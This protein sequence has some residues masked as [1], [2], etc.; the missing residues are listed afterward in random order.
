MHLLLLAPSLVFS[1]SSSNSNINEKID[2]DDGALHDANF[3]SQNNEI[4]RK[5]DKEVHHCHREIANDSN[6]NKIMTGK[7]NKNDEQSFP[8]N[9]VQCDSNDRRIV[10]T[11][12]TNFTQ[13]EDGLMA[14]TYEEYKKEDDDRVS[15]G[16]DDVLKQ[17]SRLIKDIL[18]E[19]TK[20]P[21][22]SV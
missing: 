7:R 19:K 11:E 6:N 3:S 17:D 20:D 9:E 16:D 21:K 8:H 5:T 2:D 15:S 10:I 12:K 4:R 13:A 22:V 14:E 1:L 18:M